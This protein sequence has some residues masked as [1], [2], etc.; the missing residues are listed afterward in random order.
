MYCFLFKRQCAFQKLLHTLKKR[1]SLS[2]EGSKGQA[3]PFFFNVLIA[4][5]QRN[6]CFSGCK[7][8]HYILSSQHHATYN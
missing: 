7:G 6:N 3:K 2:P 1:N 4:N 8:R 5:G